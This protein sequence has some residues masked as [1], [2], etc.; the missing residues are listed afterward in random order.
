M[1]MDL[2]KEYKS[3]QDG[4]KVKL[5]S[6]WIDYDILFVKY[7]RQPVISREHIESW[8]IQFAKSDLSSAVEKQQLAD[9]F[10]NRILYMMIK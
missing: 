8:I 3:E 9:S 6:K 5:G 7:G 2:L 10:I 1:V 4:E